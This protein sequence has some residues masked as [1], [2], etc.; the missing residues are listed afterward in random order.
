MNTCL[1]QLKKVM[2]TWRMPHSFY[3]IAHRDNLSGAARYLEL[4]WLRHPYWK[5]WKPRP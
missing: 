3:G 4:R 2:N 5:I 1:L